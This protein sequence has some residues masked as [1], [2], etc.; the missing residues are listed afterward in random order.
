[1]AKGIFNRNANEVV[2]DATS[3]SLPQFVAKYEELTSAKAETLKEAYKSIRSAGPKGGTTV[4]ELPDGEAPVTTKKVKAEKA[5][6]AEKVAKEPKPAKEPKALKEPKAPGSQLREGT[7][8]EVI[9]GLIADG[10]TNAEISAA[11]AA[12]G[13]KV[14]YSEITGARAR[15]DKANGVTTIGVVPREKKE[16]IAKAPKEKSF[17]PNDDPEAIEAALEAQGDEAVSEHEV[18]ETEA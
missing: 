16:K 4:V 6:K 3:M 13:T 8:A 18:E 12:A 15:Y 7:K 1:M 14:Y 5:P 9:R 10:K 2:A 17:D 11:L